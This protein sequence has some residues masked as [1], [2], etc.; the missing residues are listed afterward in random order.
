M[1]KPDMESGVRELTYAE[2]LREALI[3][4]MRRDERV[5]VFGED[6]AIYS[7]YKVTKGL[8]DEFGPERVKDTSISEAAIVGT[9]I[10]AAL[11]DLRPV[12]EIMYMDFITLAMDMI[13]THAAKIRFYSGG[14]VKLPLVIRTEYA[15]GRVSAAQHSQVLISCFLQSPR[16]KIVAPSNTERC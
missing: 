1:V 11:M 5:I 8:I 10:G 15:L 16:I 4:E 9:A 7:A 14:Q 6:V 2:A 13:M 12:A 3:E